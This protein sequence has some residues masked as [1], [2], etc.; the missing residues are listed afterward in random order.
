[1]RLHTETVA[2]SIECLQ[3]ATER[4]MAKDWH[5]GGGGDGNGRRRAVARRVPEAAARADRRPHGD[6]DSEARAGGGRYRQ[7]GAQHPQDVRNGGAPGGPPTITPLP[8]PLSSLTTASGSEITS[9]RASLG[10]IFWMIMHDD[11]NPLFCYILQ[12]SIVSSYTRTTGQNS[13]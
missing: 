10:L 4:R 2:K 12:L 7:E 6:D 8:P 9:T 5:R 3:N 11:D 13:Q 1:M